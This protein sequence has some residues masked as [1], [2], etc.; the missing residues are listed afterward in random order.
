MPGSYPDPRS[1]AT[2]ALLAL[3]AAY[4]ESQDSHTGS[5]I[6]TAI[7]AISR[8]KEDMRGTRRSDLSDNDPYELSEYNSAV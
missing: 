5:L 3:E 8:L 1:Y 4:E 2:T 6:L 7:Q